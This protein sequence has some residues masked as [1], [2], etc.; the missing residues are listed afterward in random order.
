VSGKLVNQTLKVISSSHTS[1]QTWLKQHPKTQVL[2]TDTG[3]KRDYTRSPYGDY[4]KNSSTY[5]PVAFKSKRY[6]PKERVLGI[7]INGKH[8]AYPF[9]ELAKLGNNELK[10]NFSGQQL[11]ITFDVENREGVIKN[12]AG[13]VL[14]VVNSFWFAWYAFH[15]KAEIFSKP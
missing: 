7:T 13:V 4:T 9:S 2:S 11:S 5:F 14:P 1:W 6:H 10:D 12:K 15:P 3:I 8:K